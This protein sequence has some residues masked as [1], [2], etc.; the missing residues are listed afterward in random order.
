MCLSNITLLFC[1]LILPLVAVLYDNNDLRITIMHSS[2][3]NRSR[4]ALLIVIVGLELLLNLESYAYQTGQSGNRPTQTVAA[5]VKLHHPDIAPHPEENNVF[6]SPET[7]TRI[8]IKKVSW[9]LL[10]CF[11]ELDS[12]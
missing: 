3:S 6:A 12:Q 11:G 5:V 7:I 2:V 4:T 8:S 1:L 9:Y 10:T